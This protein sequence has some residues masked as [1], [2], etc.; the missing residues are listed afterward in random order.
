MD[1]ALN[2]LIIE[3]SDRDVALEVRALKAAGYRVTYVVAQ[4]A[5]EMKAAL[6]KQAFDIVISDHGLPQF[7][8]PGALAVLKQSGQDIPLIVVSGTI[9]E[10]TAVA[11][12]KAGAH[13]YIMK[14]RLSRLAS[15]T[16]Q[17]L[18]DAENLRIRKQT[19]ETLKESEKKYRLLADN[20]NDVIFVLDMNLSYTYVSPSVKILSGYEPEELL[21]Q[22]TIDSLT[23]S[24]W[25]LA[26]KTVSEVMELEKSE[27]REINISRTFQLEMKRK[28]GTTV[29]TEVK[30]SFIRDENQQPMGIMGVA[31]DITERKRAEKKLEQTMS[32]LKKAVDATIQ[33]LVSAVEARDPYTAGHQLRSANLAGAIAAEMGLAQEKIDGIR[34]V[35][36]IHDIGKLSVP[37]E[38]LTKS[39]R[40]TKIEFSM[41]KG[42]S[43]AGYEMVKDVESSWPLAQIIYQHH[44]RMNGTGYPRNLKGDEILMEARI[45]AVA[46]V[47]EAM[48]S[49]RPY[50][51]PLGIETA[52][53][54]IEKN[55][56]TLYDNAPADACL[57]LFRDKG[58]ML[59]VYKITETALIS[60]FDFRYEDTG[61]RR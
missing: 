39:A 8:A 37:T 10:E 61:D 38:I 6:I 58:Y 48:A 2:V 35:G 27:H 26:M 23:T 45:M 51:P 32:S 13:D 49:H 3:D 44:E 57:R 25:D 36:S 34:M 56:G 22:P 21:K 42:H 20:I 47:V 4:T 15:A 46:D 60:A 12:M 1:T 43:Q 11:L 19:N 50:R 9:G 17:A 14:D 28:D 59:P 18:K 31:R 5:A 24:A 40:L 33:V 41:I 7:N 55:K 16:E 29:W 30:F 54:E 53:T 52:L